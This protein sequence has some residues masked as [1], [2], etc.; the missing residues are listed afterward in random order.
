MLSKHSSR[1]SD[2]SLSDLLAALARLDDGTPL[3]TPDYP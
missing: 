1:Q 2:P 3:I